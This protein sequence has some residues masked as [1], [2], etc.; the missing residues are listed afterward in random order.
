MDFVDE[1]N[2]SNH[3]TRLIPSKW[4]DEYALVQ[5][6]SPT[7]MWFKFFAFQFHEIE[8]NGSRMS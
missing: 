1:M 5:D 4:N 2:H 3:P 6:E 8:T 7:V